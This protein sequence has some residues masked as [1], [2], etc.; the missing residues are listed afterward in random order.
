MRT[1]IDIM[2]KKEYCASCHHTKT[3]K[4]FC[5]KEGCDS[6]LEDG[7]FIYGE[8]IGRWKDQTI[9][10]HLCHTHFQE[11]RVKYRGVVEYCGSQFG[12]KEA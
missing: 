11:L 6:I 10:I 2:I 12:G 4:V 1:G 8:L 9:I 3:E 5:D 7:D